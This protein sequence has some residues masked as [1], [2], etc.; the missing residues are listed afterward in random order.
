MRVTYTSNNSGG[1][2]WLNDQDWKA[3]EDSGWVVDW[4]SNRSNEYRTVDGSGRWLGGLAAKAY[5][6][7]L[8]LGDAILLWE[9]VT[10]ENSADLGCSCCGAPHFFEFDGDNG[11]TE[12]YSPERPLSGERYSG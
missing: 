3:L 8:T 5:I 1:S 7:G 9:D 6:E 12:Y 2:W 10:G 4:F 11:E